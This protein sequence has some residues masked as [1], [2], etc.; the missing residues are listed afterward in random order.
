MDAKIP[1][2]GRMFLS[3]IANQD[4]MKQIKARYNKTSPSDISEEEREILQ[5]EMLNKYG[6]QL[7]STDEYARLQ[8]ITKRAEQVHP[9]F[10][11]ENP[12]VT[13]VV[14]AATLSTLLVHEQAKQ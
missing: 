4:Y 14:N 7:I 11:N 8:F 12:D 9:N 2:S 1:G 13:R 10:L 5:K 3:Y 6:N